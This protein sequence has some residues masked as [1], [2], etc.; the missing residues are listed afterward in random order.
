MAGIVSYHYRLLSFLK[1]RIETDVS[2]HIVRTS[3]YLVG[4]IL[5]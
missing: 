1:F 3:D 2:L 4:E 5:D